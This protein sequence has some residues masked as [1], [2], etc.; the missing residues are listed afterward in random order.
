MMSQGN[1][2]IAG[3]DP[4]IVSSSSPFQSYESMV[5]TPSGSFSGS[6]SFSRGLS[7]RQVPAALFKGCC[8]WWWWL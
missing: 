2:L 3:E 8:W 6:G 7:F 1:S 4:D 5:P